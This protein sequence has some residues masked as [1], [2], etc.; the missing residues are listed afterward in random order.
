MIIGR[1]HIQSKRK[2]INFRI[3]RSSVFLVNQI[4]ELEPCLLR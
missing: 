2:N 3:K 4:Y 1:L